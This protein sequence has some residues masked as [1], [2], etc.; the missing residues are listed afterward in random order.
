MSI[1]IGSKNK[2]KNTTIGHQYNGDNKES[3]KKSC[4]EKHPIIFTVLLSLLVGF[5]LLFS[6]WKSLAVWIESF[7]K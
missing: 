4:F 3:N 7:F 1:R 5:A 6:F 2:F